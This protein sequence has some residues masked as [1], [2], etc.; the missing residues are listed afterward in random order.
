VGPIIEDLARTLDKVY[1]DKGVRCELALAAGL[2]FRGDP[3]DLTEILGNL[4]DNAYKYCG[5]RVRVTTAVAAADLT[6]KIEDDGRGITPDEALLLFKRGS[7]ADESVPGHGIGL[8]VARE[9]VELYHGRLSLE[10]SA[11]GG[12]A[13]EVSLARTGAI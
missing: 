11:L 1:R 2:T 5:R 9:I 7:R 3:G 6:I 12:A 13:F 8:A 4:M 10:R